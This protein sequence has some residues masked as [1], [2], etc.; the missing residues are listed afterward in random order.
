MKLEVLSS[1]EVCGSLFLH[2]E[3]FKQNCKVAK[4]TLLFLIIHRILLLIKET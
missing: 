3:I 4:N 2:L 1:L